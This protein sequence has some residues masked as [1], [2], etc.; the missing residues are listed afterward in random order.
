MTQCSPFFILELDSS[1]Y[2]RPEDAVFGDKILNSEPELLI[3][4]AGEV[5]E[6]LFPRHAL[7]PRVAKI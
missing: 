1:R 4:R 7:S 6:Q 3:N 5:G 2:F